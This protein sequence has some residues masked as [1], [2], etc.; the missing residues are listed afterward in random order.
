M[1]PLAQKSSQLN[2][3]WNFSASSQNNA[4][5][6]VP[7]EAESTS[8]SIF[9]LPESP[10]K[11]LFSELVKAG[12]F[13]PDGTYCKQVEASLP[14]AAPQTVSK[15]LEEL[16]ALCL[17][18]LFCHLLKQTEIYQLQKEGVFKIVGSWV[19]WILGHEYA[20][21]VLNRQGILLDEWISADTIQESFAR[22]A[23]IDIR[24]EMPESTHQQL[25]KM[26]LS[27]AGFLQNHPKL[28]M[29]KLVIT[30]AKRKPVDVGYSCF[31]TL[32]LEIFGRKIDISLINKLHSPF[33]FGDDDLYIEL[34]SKLLDNHSLGV[35]EPIEITPQ[36][37]KFLGWH[38]IPLRMIKTK[39]SDSYNSINV[40][41]S[42][43][44]LLTSTKGF[45]CFS[46]ELQKRLFFNYLKILA[47]EKG[48]EEALAMLHKATKINMPDVPA[49]LTGFSFNFS[50][51]LQLYDPQN[52]QKWV[53]FLFKELGPCHKKSL[54]EAQKSHI[55]ALHELLKSQSI[56][57][58]VLSAFL[59]IHAKL[60][61]IRKK[62]FQQV[63]TIW[64]C[65]A[66]T[67]EN[68]IVQLRFA[69][70]KI[71]LIL[72]FDLLEVL[73]LLK[74]YFIYEEH[75][76]DEQAVR[77]LNL[78]IWPLFQG[79]KDQ[80]PFTPIPPALKMERSQIEVV[81]DLATAFLDCKPLQ[82]LGFCLLCYCGELT[83]ARSH[84]GLLIKKL[85][86]VLASAV[87]P[88][89]RLAALHHFWRY[90]QMNLPADT[91]LEKGEPIKQFNRLVG[92]AVA[93]GEEMRAEFCKLFAY[94]RR[95]EVVS[96]VHEEWS[97]LVGQL[98]PS[99][100]TS[101]AAELINRYLLSFPPAPLCALRI[102]KSMAQKPQIG[103][104]SLEARFESIYNRM[105]SQSKTPSE[106]LSLLKVATLVAKRNK[107]Q[108]ASSS[109]IKC[110]LTLVQ[111]SLEFF[112]EESISLLD[113]VCEQKLL[114]KDPQAHAQAR[115]E[116]AKSLFKHGRIEDAL[117]QLNRAQ[118][119]LKD[120]DL[121]RTLL[122]WKVKLS[123]QPKA[124]ED[125]FHGLLE[126]MLKA[127]K[128]SLSLSASRELIDAI[129]TLLQCNLGSRLSLASGLS[130]KGLWLFKMLKVQF[131]S[132]SFVLQPLKH[133]F[134]EY[135]RMIA[136]AK[137]EMDADE[138][139]EIA[140]LIGAHCFFD[141]AV[142]SQKTPSE[143]MEALSL[144]FFQSTSLNIRIG[145]FLLL[146]ALESLK[147]SDLQF[148]KLVQAFPGL[149]LEAKSASLAAALINRFIQ[150]YPAIFEAADKGFH[151]N[152]EKL[153]ECANAPFG[154]RDGLRALICRTLAYINHESA[155][156]AVYN[157]WNG[158]KSSDL[159]LDLVKIYL[160]VNPLWAFTIK[161]SSGD[162]SS[163]PINEL[164]KAF[165]LIC[166]EY[167]ESAQAIST[168]HGLIL[169]KLTEQIASH[170]LSSMLS[171]DFKALVLWFNKK[172]FENN[173]ERGDSLFRLL[174]QKGIYS[175]NSSEAGLLQLSIS[176]YH[177][178]QGRYE[179]ALEMCE[180]AFLSGSQEAA[181][182]AL[183]DWSDQF[184]HGTLLKLLLMCCHDGLSNC[185]SELLA[186][187]ILKQLNQL[188]YVS[189]L[190][191]KLAENLERLIKVLKELGQKVFVQN[192]LA[193]LP[194]W[195]IEVQG[196]IERYDLWLD[197]LR[198]YDW[199][200]IGEPENQL[201]D[202]LIKDKAIS[203]KRGAPW[204]ADNH[205][206]QFFT[207]A[208]DLLFKQSL[209][210]CY[211]CLCH[212]VAKAADNLPDK[213]FELIFQCVTSLCEMEQHQ[214]AI[215]LLEQ[216]KTGLPG[217]F[218]PQQ[219]VAWKNII[220]SLG[221]AS[222]LAA[223]ILIQ[224]S[225]VF[226]SDL[227]QVKDLAEGV[228]HHQMKTKNS[229][230]Q[231]LALKLAELYGLN[232]SSHWRVVFV[233]LIADDPST[234]VLCASLL[235]NPMP[236]NG[237][238]EDRSKSWLSFL[239]F[240][241]KHQPTALI[242]LLERYKSILDFELNRIDFFRAAGLFLDGFKKLL[243]HPGMDESTL[244][245]CLRTVLHLE[246]MLNILYSTTEQE[247]Q[248]LSI[249][250]QLLA[251]PYADCYEAACRRLHS[252]KIENSKRYLAT[253]KI[254]VLRYKE[255]YANCQPAV[256]YA[257]REII[258]QTKKINPNVWSNLD[259][260]EF[261]MQ[262]ERHEGEKIYDTAVLILND[263]KTRTEEIFK[264]TRMFCEFLKK[265]KCLTDD[266]HYY[267]FLDSVVNHP[268][269]P[270]LFSKSEFNSLLVQPM[271]NFLETHQIVIQGEDSGR[272]NQIDEI[273]KKMDLGFLEAQEKRCFELLA[274]QLCS[275]YHLALSPEVF[276]KQYLKICRQLCPDFEKFWPSILHIFKTWS[277]E[278][279]VD[280]GWGRSKADV[281]YLTEF[282]AQLVLDVDHFVLET[283][284]AA[285]S[286]LLDPN[287]PAQLKD[288]FYFKKYHSKGSDA[289][290]QFAKV[291]LNAMLGSL[292]LDP[293]LNRFHTAGMLLQALLVSALAPQEAY[294]PIVQLGFNS[295]DQE[296]KIYTMQ[297]LF[298]NHLNS[299]CKNSIPAIPI[300]LRAKSWILSG[301]PSQTVID[302]E[303][304]L[305][306]IFEVFKLLLQKE[307]E[308]S[309][310]LRVRRVLVLFEEFY[311]LLKNPSDFLRCWNLIMN[312]CL[313]YPSYATSV[314]QTE[315]M[316]RLGCDFEIFPFLPHASFLKKVFDE[317]ENGIPK[318]R[319]AFQ[320]VFKSHLLLGLQFIDFYTDKSNSENDLRKNRLVL[321]LANFV[322]ECSA[323]DYLFE[324][325]AELSESLKTLFRHVCLMGDTQIK[326]IAYRLLTYGN[327]KEADWNQLSQM[328]VAEL[329]EK[330]ISCCLP[331]HPKELFVEQLYRT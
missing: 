101:L 317:V 323:H 40:R 287:R 50:Y 143:T 168:V 81:S 117:L 130:I 42:L 274:D 95:P 205:Q 178:S 87:E 244:K 207:L 275:V 190:Q 202:A 210:R 208:A 229:R 304:F 96:A 59:L 132:E 24:I 283:S 8:S 191:I 56:P 27:I 9:N 62:E 149:L 26:G 37:S 217:Q 67:G 39:W 305:R 110:Y 301:K 121:V 10:Q 73:T 273:C 246:M 173:P 318:S 280:Y 119:Y 93:S 223:Q 316:K 232:S 290:V 240:L 218:I 148:G 179:R 212:L 189:D 200:S 5:T 131:E 322:M 43:K 329:R 91:L 321:H 151:E 77:W 330:L 313:L 271:L 102:L 166:K 133:H 135:C 243:C 221:A 111:S 276:A 123:D 14:K 295:Y 231:N 255:F 145:C 147:K 152:L 163:L 100:F 55:E 85:P 162:N 269:M 245:L 194:S 16:N 106:L 258:D 268:Q 94:S 104:S 328:D 122:D 278:K 20:S 88:K 34:P 21:E 309:L 78:V 171:E 238:L 12:V 161:S 320:E 32:S 160:P 3:F 99:A 284:Y 261:Y 199:E 257:L 197:L 314:Q 188:S 182:D 84:L 53:P 209:E 169:E 65:A 237:P 64:A 256:Y 69:Q 181:A 129:I 139:H 319:L 113:T 109:V 48:P 201:L 241:Q 154:E 259:L 35:A 228:F 254:A 170:R 17:L 138:N 11:K 226:E 174:Y 220:A 297:L 72:P 172:T 38:A 86:D 76:L 165:R 61:E 82:W 49:A 66:K 33:L 303:V 213:T 236:F 44:F 263:P 206:L 57:F 230:S 75:K 315:E 294:E 307:Q 175:G 142:G 63:T 193:V 80:I 47:G 125:H 36:G 326:L 227:M 184:C 196:L 234:Q 1:N 289:L 126:C 120:D 105:N 97:S 253:V 260:I 52:A 302:R 29:A 41:G 157:C 18:D 92:S 89:V 155:F 265:H 266:I 158:E 167:L 233:N 164:E 272:L 242:A 306:E 312:V 186:K 23:D 251:S 25:V 264:L 150:T 128:D 124:R 15:L 60:L 247:L 112:L 310:S 58:E 144:E 277:S 19:F 13:S 285:K 54:E 262:A 291:L 140:D 103:Y 324:K 187:A 270:A 46:A 204:G 74:T 83:Q 159:S 185:R 30:G 70:D 183:L 31:H 235:S 141:L 134:D 281:S 300:S 298:C 153:K 203:S 71:S 118:F 286:N 293:E 288:P 51:F 195:K 108:A 308:D 267:C 216:L 282:Q 45:T 225:K 79:I 114:A 192:L 215:N 311:P 90:F 127:C 137:I 180:A 176:R 250:E 279:S 296:E 28:A 331:S 2:P 198:W 115:L 252:G 239:Q 136:Q 292:P 219:R 249:N 7:L 177:F 211:Q 248:A 98:K 68:S 6:P 156:E 146:C 4:P 224:E 107:G 22:P 327:L 116:I 214:K 299:F 325:D 222:N